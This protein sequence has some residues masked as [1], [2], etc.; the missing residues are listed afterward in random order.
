MLEKEGKR[1]GKRLKKRE[2][3]V[4]QSDATR[5]DARVRSGSAGTPHAPGS[6]ARR[7]QERNPALTEWRFDRSPAAPPPPPPFPPEGLDSGDPPSRARILFRFIRSGISPVRTS[8]QDDASIP[9]AVTSPLASC[10]SFPSMGTLPSMQIASLGSYNAIG[11]EFE[12]CFCRINIF[13][14]FLFFLLILRW[15]GGGGLGF[16]GV[17]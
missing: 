15:G 3:K 13:F 14:L 2:K 6:R 5:R 12:S 17:L 8:A 11:S 16:G 4:E 1:K 10:F 7:V 9:R